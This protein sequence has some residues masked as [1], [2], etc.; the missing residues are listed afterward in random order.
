VAEAIY[1]GAIKRKHL[2]VLTPV[3]KISYWISRIFPIRYER[4]MARNLRSELEG[5]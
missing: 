5:A 2:L 3:G 1:R 4:M